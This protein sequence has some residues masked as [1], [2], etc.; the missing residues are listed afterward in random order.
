MAGRATTLDMEHLS[1]H[2][3]EWYYLG[4]VTA[5][6]DLAPLEEH[7]LA[8]SCCVERAEE[9][10]DYMGAIRLGLIKGGFDLE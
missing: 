6:P 10:Q 9:T 3:L 1:D 7:I 5:E 4:M 8:C 2:D